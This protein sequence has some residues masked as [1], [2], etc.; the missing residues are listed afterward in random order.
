MLSHTPPGQSSPRYFERRPLLARHARIARGLR[1]AAHVIE[2][3][4]ADREIT[5]GDIPLIVLHAVNLHDAQ[6]ACREIDWVR[7]FRQQFYGTATVDDII[8][9]PN[10]GERVLDAEVELLR[11]E[12]RFVLSGGL[13]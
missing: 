13:R 11:T 5:P 12:A 2:I 8:V 1:L 3:F 6:A 7:G 9:D 4:G 10:S